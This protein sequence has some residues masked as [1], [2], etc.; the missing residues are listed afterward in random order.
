MVGLY[1][2]S[3]RTTRHPYNKDVILYRMRPNGSDNDEILAF[4]GG[5]GTIDANSW[6]PDNKRIAFVMY[7]TN[8]FGLVNIFDELFTRLGVKT[9]KLLPNNSTIF[10]FL[11]INDFVCF[12]VVKALKKFPN[13]NSHFLGE[14]MRLFN[15]V[16]LGL[17]VD[18]ER[19]LKVPAVRNVVDLSIIGL[20]D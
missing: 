9:I 18:T 11:T 20:P 5:Q 7:P 3:S 1:Q 16:H 19:G 6:L 13:V 2:F 12:T 4:K 14:S 17:A 8:P 10:C 15:K